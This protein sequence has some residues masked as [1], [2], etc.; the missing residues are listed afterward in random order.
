MKKKKVSSVGCQGKKI[1]REL[2]RNLILLLLG[3]WTVDSGLWTSHAQPS[4]SPSRLDY[5]SFRLVTERNIFNSRRSARYVPSERTRTRSAPT[6]AFALVGTMSYEKGL[7]AFFDGSS[8]DYRKV[9]KQEDTIAGFKIADIQPSY[10]KL[11]SPTNQVELRVGMQLRHGE[12]GEWQVADRTE[13]S[14]PTSGQRASRV[15]AQAGASRNLPGVPAEPDQIALSSTNALGIEPLEGG[16]PSS[17]DDPQQPAVAAEAPPASEGGTNEVL[18]RLR[19]RAAA[20]RGENP[21]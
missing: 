18:E 3:L 7:F 2:T 10:V 9:L 8:S 20:D 12:S 17:V 6:D 15:P 21:Q 16:P 4:N 19:R 5:T 1:F 14:T 13:T 11:A